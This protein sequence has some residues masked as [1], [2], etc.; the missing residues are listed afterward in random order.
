MTSQPQGRYVIGPLRVGTAEVLINTNSVDFATAARWVFSDLT[1]PS[2]SPATTRSVVFDTVE[3]AEP[4]V[5]WSVHRN[6]E[7]CELQLRP[8]AVLV[9]Q[10]WELNRLA[11][12]SHPTSI[13]SAA[14]AIGGRAALLLGASHSGKTTLAGWLAAHHDAEYLTD[15]VAS[16]DAAG[17]VAPFPRPLGVR[18]DSPLASIRPSG[19][20]SAHTGA[21][22]AERFMPDERLVPIRHLGAS[23]C[24]GPVPVTA[25]VFP[26]FDP[27]S[28]LEVHALDMADA[29]E[30][31][32]L[33]TPG[34][35][36]HGRPVFDRLTRLVEQATAFDI[37]YPD[38]RE[39]AP[40][41]A[42]AL[43]EVP[44]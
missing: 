9:H 35:T 23:A 11:I 38:V 18:A 37:R 12:E 3:H 32:A 33:L 15:E 36:E 13:H 28:A 10:Q 25:L 20:S 41:V 42:T 43:R 39:A 34:L 27:T 24:S 44:A 7:P 22:T 5:R 14:V 29:F 30:R 19:A 17:R 26:T 16:I 21:V 6:G 1:V 8:D 40:A 31:L 4:T 2:T